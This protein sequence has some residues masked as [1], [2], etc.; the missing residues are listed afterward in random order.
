VATYEDE[1]DDDDVMDEEGRTRLKLKVIDFVIIFSAD[2]D[3]TN[4]FIAL[5]YIAASLVYSF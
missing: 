1:V 5:R 3:I 2:A 4:A